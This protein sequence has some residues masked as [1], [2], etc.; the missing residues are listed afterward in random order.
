MTLLWMR[1]KI[2]RLSSKR[3]S[4]SK[5]IGGIW[6]GLLNVAFVGTWPASF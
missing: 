6:K 1:K 2:K 5:K 3:R 4:K